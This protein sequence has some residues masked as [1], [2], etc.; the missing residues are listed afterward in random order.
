[1]NVIGADFL[2][3]L[4]HDPVRKLGPV[5]LAA[6]MPEV[7]MSKFC[8][9][10]GF[11][12]IGCRFVGEMSMTAKDSLL[13]APWPGRTI[14]QHFDVVIRFQQQH[15]RRAYGVEIHAVDMTESGQDADVAGGCSK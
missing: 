7:K 13:E 4:E 5:A 9:H 15:N 2:Q 12:S 1:M 10:E 14:L 3:A 8:G 11:G 6:E